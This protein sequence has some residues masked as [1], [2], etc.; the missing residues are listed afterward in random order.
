[1]AHLQI[2]FDVLVIII[3]F[4]SLSIAVSWALRTGEAD[5]RDFCLV[6]ALFTIVLVVTTL[7][8][9]LLLNVEGY[10]AWTWYLL[11]GILEV[12]NLAVVVGLIAFLLRAY[13][14]R[15]SRT[16][17]WIFTV[18]MLICDGLMLSPWGAVLDAPNQSIRLGVGYQIVSAF[19]V[20][21][22]TFALVLGYGWLRRV[23][24]TDKRAFVI[25]LLVFATVGY[26]ETL[27]SF[28]GDIHQPV[29]ALA[30]ESDFLYSSIPYGLYGIFVIVYF[31]NYFVPASIQDDQ[32]FEAFLARYGITEREREIILKVIQGKSNADIARE[33]VISIATVKTHLYNIYGKIGVNS[34]YNL[35]ARVRSGQWRVDGPISRGRSSI[36]N[37]SFRAN[38]PK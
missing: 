3:G 6:Y 23:W 18:L 13:H 20:A 24:N 26:A 8:K 32:V 22:F 30:A 12:L 7:K 11:S 9:Y 35:L 34:R 16:L 29:A 37:Q 33:L 19:Y 27:L 17:I 1:M 14:I 25:G 21:S 36:S 2:A 28:W 4:A 10:S 38:R 15:A 31:L 5:L